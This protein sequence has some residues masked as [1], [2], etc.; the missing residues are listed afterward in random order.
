[1]A[2]K[3]AWGGWESR[4]SVFRVM[5]KKYSKL[6][7]SPFQVLPA[8]PGHHESLTGAETIPPMGLSPSCGVGL[9]WFS[10]VSIG[11]RESLA[12]RY[13]LTRFVWVHSGALGFPVKSLYERG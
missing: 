1:M 9:S 2:V 4:V 11:S 6:T 3:V 5:T 7:F 12:T 10:H 8:L 13:T